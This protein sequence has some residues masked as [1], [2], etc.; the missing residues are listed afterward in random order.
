MQEGVGELGVW[1]EDEGEDGWE[2]ELAPDEGRVMQYSQETMKKKKAYE[3]EK[4][5]KAQEVLRTQQRTNSN[6]LRLGT[7]VT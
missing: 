5:R 6:S 7:R 1:S 3:R 2:D 4:R